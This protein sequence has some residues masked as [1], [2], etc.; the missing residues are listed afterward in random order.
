VAD[1]LSRL[2]ISVGAIACGRVGF[3]ATGDAR[4]PGDSSDASMD[5]LGAFTSPVMILSTAGFDDDDPEVSADGLELYFTS[6]R[7]GGV[8]G[9]DIYLATRATPSDAWGTPA[10]VTQLS[11]AND[12]T[13]PTLCC[14]DLVMYLGSDRA[15]TFGNDDVYRTT[16]PT[17]TTPWSTPVHIDPLSTASYDSAAVSENEL[18]AIIDTDV[19]TASRHLKISTRISA[20]S[21]WPT[22]V[23]IAELTDM[24]NIEVDPFFVSPTQIAFTAIRGAGYF[25]LFTSQRPF[26]GA[27]FEPPVRIDGVNTGEAERDPWLSPD[28]RTIYFVRQNLAGDYDMFTATR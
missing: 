24:A 15:G 27:G 5:A 26:V 11:S 23:P 9:A 20:G 21:P 18:E 8:G 3:D 10:V 4:T 17:L 13:Q 28:G 12:E 14:G 1:V 2:A 16:R 6:N 7:P 22:P 19:G 25:D